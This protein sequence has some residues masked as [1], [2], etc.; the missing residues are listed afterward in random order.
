MT[1]AAL[2]ARVREVRAILVRQGVN[3]VPEADRILGEILTELERPSRESAETKARRYLAE[4]RLEVVLVADDEIEAT[5][6]GDGAAYLLGW[7]GAWHCSCPARTDRCAHLVALRLVV[8]AGPST[9]P[10]RAEAGQS[11]PVS[12]AE[13]TPTPDQRS[14]ARPSGGWTR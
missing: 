7:H 4:G 9:R 10:N 8:L 11:D 5:C 14:G 6:R 12:P 1:D 13:T 3:G 2:R